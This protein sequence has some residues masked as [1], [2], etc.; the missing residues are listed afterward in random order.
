MNIEVLNEKEM[1]TVTLNGRLDSTTAGQLEDTFNTEL[2]ENVKALT[3]DLGQVDFVS[4][5]GLRVLVGAY[6][7]LNGREMIIS[8]A[9]PSVMDVLRMSGLLKVF[10]TI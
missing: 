1:L 5:K 4:S 8:G 7:A 6:K 9:N 3:V 10:K 2:N